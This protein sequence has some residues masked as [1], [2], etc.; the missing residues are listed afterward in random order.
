[1]TD[2]HGA[3]ASSVYGCREIQTPNLQKLADTGAKFTRAYAATPVCSPSRLTYLTGTLP[4][5]HTVQ[6]WLRPPDSFGPQSRRWAE[7]LTSYSSLL[8]KSGYTC[9]LTGK[10]HM[11]HDDT[12]QE[13]FTYWATVPGGG[14]T[15][16]DA[17]FVRNGERI[18]KPG[19]K[20]DAIGDFALEFLAQQR[21]KTDPF[22]LLVPF[23]APHTPYDFTPESDQAPYEKSEFGCFPRGPSHPWANRELVNHQNKQKSMAGYASLITGMDRNVGRVLS[24]LERE[25]LR[26]NTTI[27]FTADQGW[28]AGHHG[29]WGKG[30]GTWPFNMYE[31]SVR[32]PLIWN[33]PGRIRPGETLDPMVSSYDF[34]PTI[35]DWAGVP[36]PKAAPERVGRSYAGFLRGSRPS[37]WPD[38][39]FFEYSMVRGVR[40]ANLKLVVRTDE[41]PSEFYDLEA[42]PGEKQNLWDDLAHARQRGDL[43]RQVE[44]FFAKSGAP[45]LADW[46]RNV[47]QDLTVYRR[48]Q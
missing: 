27:V 11:G 18:R 8:A 4:S 31:E 46:K 10:W 9:G 43:T 45:P 44:A 16:K 23:Y 30:N 2:D 7:G 37:R 6:D 14:G 25:G 40:T 13:G 47:K 21:G 38:R 39:V 17:E 28:N 35:L 24:Y 22:F 29:F 41:W 42:D 15:F 12:A 3:W 34:F 36:A 48:V 5:R 1:M 20:E 32:V 19:F 26:D 33:H